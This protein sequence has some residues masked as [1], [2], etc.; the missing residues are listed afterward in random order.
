MKNVIWEIKNA[1]FFLKR[2]TLKLLNTNQP[3]QYDYAYG[4]MFIYFRNAKHL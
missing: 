2:F 1:N 3:N 4:I